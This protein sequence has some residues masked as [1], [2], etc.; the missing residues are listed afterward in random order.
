MQP[1]SGRAAT[2]IRVLVADTSRI[3]TQL[4]S[5]AL[6]RDPGLAVITW[7][8]DPMSLIPTT[9]TRDVNVLAISSTLTGHSLGA[10]EIVRD[11][12]AMRAATKAV[13]LMDTHEE[14]SVIQAFRAGARGIFRRDGSVEMFCKCINSV[15]DARAC[16]S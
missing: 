14:E 7:D 13:V 10:L 9:V 15:C 4:L 11:L 3:H 8:G 5:D 16:V 6:Q 2:E 1:L 12:H